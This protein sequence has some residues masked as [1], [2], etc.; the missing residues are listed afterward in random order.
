[1]PNGRYRSPLNPAQS[2][3]LLRTTHHFIV[4]SSSQTMVP[5]PR[6]VPP[7]LNQTGP[8]TAETRSHTKRKALDTPANPAT[9]PT[10][11]V[12]PPSKRKATTSAVNPAHT[13]SDTISRAHQYGTRE[14]NQAHPG[15]AAGHYRKTGEE[16]SSAAQAKKDERAAKAQKKADAAEAKQQRAAT[17]T[18]GAARR[19]NELADKRSSEA[20]KEKPPVVAGSKKVSAVVFLFYVSAR[21]MIVWTFWV[22]RRQNSSLRRTSVLRAK[23]THEP[24][25]RLRALTK[26]RTRL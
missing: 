7:R 4:P 13:V 6:P 24:P 5:K 21:T 20:D 17:A 2:F 10:S 1:M 16:V 23:L 25:S 8:T 15:R 22:N 18:E 9:S 14:T 26:R 3:F 12:P 11:I 19:L